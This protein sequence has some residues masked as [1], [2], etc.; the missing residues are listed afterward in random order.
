M[1]SH[2]GPRCDTDCWIWTGRLHEGGYGI[3][4]Y[5]GVEVRVHLGLWIAINGPKPDGYDLDHLCRVRPCFNPDHLELTT[6]KENL[7]R[8][9]GNKGE[10]N[11]MAKLTEKQVA[12]IKIAL[13]KDIPGRRIGEFFGVKDSTI[14]NIK[15]EIIWSSVEPDYSWDV[16]IIPNEPFQQRSPSGSSHGKAKLTEEDVVVIRQRYADGEKPKKIAVDYPIDP[17]GISN[18]VAR[19]TWKHVD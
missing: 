17:S 12:R 8:G 6:R 5:R 16:S 9:S 7:N 11:G 1:Q 2:P 10:V 18:I 19:R 3:V 4:S 14:S 13:E 15:H